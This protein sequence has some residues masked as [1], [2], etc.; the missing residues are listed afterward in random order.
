M[1][2][3]EIEN[4]KRKVKFMKILLNKKFR[5]LKILLNENSVK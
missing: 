3:T 2:S 1:K 4:K 5:S